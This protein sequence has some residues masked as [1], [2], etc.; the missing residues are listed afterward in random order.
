VAVLG[1]QAEVKHVASTLNKHF[2]TIQF[3]VIRAVRKV[4]RQLTN[5]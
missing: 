3:A 1:D 2:S 4:V 5:K